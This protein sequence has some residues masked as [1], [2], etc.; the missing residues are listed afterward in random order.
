MEKKKLQFS[1]KLGYGV[2]DLGGNLYF[3]IM[4]FHLLR[5]LTDVALLNSM[6]A[7]LATAIG[8]ISDAISDPLVGYFSD[9]TRSKWGRRRPFIFVGAFT[10]FLTMVI[11][12]SNPRLQGNQIL[13][14]I[15]A[16][17]A[18]ILLSTAYTLVNIPYGALA[19]ELTNDFHEKTVLNGYRQ[20]FAIAGTFTGVL[21][22][23]AILQPFSQNLNLG[24]TVYGTLMGGV[25]M[26][27]SLI[28][29]FV[30]KE[31]PALGIDATATDLA[32][33]RLAEAPEQTESSAGVAKGVNIFLAYWG[34][35]KDKTFLCALFPWTLHITG[36]SVIMAAFTYYCKYIYKN[37]GAFTFCMGAL[38]VG[39]TVALFFWVWI[40][41]KIGKKATYNLGMGLFAV[42]VLVF[43]FFGE[44]LGWIFA[45]VI[46]AIGGVGY[47]THYVI[48]YAL[49]PDIVEYDYAKTGKRREGLYYATWTLLTKVG[50]ALSFVIAGIVLNLAGYTANVEQSPSAILGIK[51][52]CG[53][54]P[55]LFFI[56]GIIVLCFYP[57]NKA[58]YEE[59]MK[60]IG[61]SN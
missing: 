21:A 22:I 44:Q 32:G 51:L 38:L 40:S 4:G 42:S 41:K 46:M 1:T 33:A 17:V 6:L 10:L 34:I 55:A 18:F 54:I 29:F 24:W 19:P 57:I 8:K 60:K 61:A 16:A 14:C 9:R 31:Q 48:P 59:I 12:F 56:A 50:Q 39:S 26:I 35:L 7:G 58:F 47:S 13:L 25:M 37:E 43:F 23:G 5:F 27:S 20:I 2:G 49:V 11:M 3:T 53:P 30:V 52:L 15:W 28:T 45:T 36:V